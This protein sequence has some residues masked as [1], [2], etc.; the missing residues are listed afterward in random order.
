MLWYF[1]WSIHFI[2]PN[3]LTCRSPL[4][5]LEE[6]GSPRVYYVYGHGLIGREDA[7]GN[8]HSYHTGMRG[9]TTFLTDQTGRVTDRYTYGLYGELEQPEGSTR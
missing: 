5:Q 9:S 2:V 1:I 4:T 7:K 6:D 8:Y 3:Q